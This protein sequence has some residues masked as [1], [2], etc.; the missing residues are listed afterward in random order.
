VE[1]D[2]P[3]SEEIT[4]ETALPQSTFGVYTPAPT[5]TYPFDRVF[6]PEADQA[7]VYHD[8][9][10]PVLEEVLNGYNCTLFA[11]GQTGTGKTYTMQ[12]DLSPTLT[13]NP[14]ADA[15]II[16]RALH[17]LFLHLENSVSDYSVKVSFVELYNEELRDLLASEFKEPSANAQPM[18]IASGQGTNGLKIFDDAAKKGTFIQGL[19]EAHVQDAKHAIDVLR[20]GSERRQ[21]AATKFNDHSRCVN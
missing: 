11:Y 6:G 10:A 5:R 4:I 16:P 8:A 19:E 3:R 7:L 2:G 21:I 13:G 17:K 1:T 15:G 14:S 9:V 18:G 12:G 20:K